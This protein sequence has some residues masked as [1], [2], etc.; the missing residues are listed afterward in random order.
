MPGR[1][2]NSRPGFILPTSW[3]LDAL[4]N[5]WENY[6]KKCFLTK[7]KE[8]RI[9]RWSA[10]EQ[11]C[12]V[13]HLLHQQNKKFFL[14][15]RSTLASVS[16]NNKQWDEPYDITLITS[17]QNLFIMIHS[18]NRGFAVC[19]PY[20]HNMPLYNHSYLSQEPSTLSLHC[21]LYA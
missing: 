13:K 21:Y 3:W 8:T 6:R 14:H 15:A 10:F 4:K 16:S 20:V 2:S 5:N 1:E 19:N 17:L 7:E 11:L 18:L 9:K 12:T